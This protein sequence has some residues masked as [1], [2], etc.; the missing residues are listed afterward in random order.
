MNID[1]ILADKLLLSC[2]ELVSSL[3]WR[4]LETTNQSIMKI[5]K[6]KDEALL[7]KKFI[8]VRRMIRIILI[9]YC[10]IPYN[11]VS[12]IWGLLET[13]NRSIMKIIKRNMELH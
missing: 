12:V 2:L 4:F 8:E 11:D 10:I 5:I 7:E 1:L 9:S 6:M 3:T 13:T